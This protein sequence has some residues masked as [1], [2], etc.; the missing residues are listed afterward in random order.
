MKRGSAR[1]S[2]CACI[3][4]KISV[5]EVVVAVHSIAVSRPRQFGPPEGEESCASATDG[6]I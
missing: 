4:A 1:A 2:Q 5:P 6:P 3:G